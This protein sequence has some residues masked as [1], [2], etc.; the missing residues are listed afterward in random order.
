MTRTTRVFVA[1]LTIQPGQP[2]RRYQSAET[3][4]FSAAAQKTASD[5]QEPSPE[6]KSPN[7]TSAASLSALCSA[8]LPPQ[9]E[10]TFSPSV[11][12]NTF[13]S[14]TSWT[15]EIPT[16]IWDNIAHE[17]LGL[18]ED[19]TP[20]LLALSS[21]CKA[22]H[23]PAQRA[24]VRHLDVQDPIAIEELMTS[25][26]RK[27]ALGR[28]TKSLTVNLMKPQSN[29]RLENSQAQEVALLGLL[30]LVPR[31]THVR[32]QC[33]FDCPESLIQLLTATLKNVKSI[34]ICSAFGYNRLVY[35]TDSTLTR[36]NSG[37]PKLVRQ[38]K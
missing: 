38:S 12:Y 8:F 6:W 16:E 11:E 23:Y 2:Y 36:L 17:C 35:I 14:P 18:G 29:S 21:T 22:T 30:P 4:L 26:L 19:S 32:L 3:A 5:I 13:S 7:A 34:T 9:F 28:A 37:F 25:L 1:P 20:T 24:L 27:P 15:P 10:P 33:E 31:I